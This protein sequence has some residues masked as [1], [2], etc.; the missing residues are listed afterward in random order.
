LRCLEKP[1]VGLCSTVL[2]VVSDT[3]ASSKSL[4]TLPRQCQRPSRAKHGQNDVPYPAALGRLYSSTPSLRETSRTCSRGWRSRNKDI[5]V[6]VIR[7]QRLLTPAVVL[8]EPVSETSTSSSISQRH[9]VNHSKLDKTKVRTRV[10]NRCLPLGG[11][12]KNRPIRLSRHA[13]RAPT[14][15][16][17]LAGE[18]RHDRLVTHE[19]QI[20][21]LENVSGGSGLAVSRLRGVLTARPQ[22]RYPSTQP[23]RHQKAGSG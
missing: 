7:D 6:L 8:P 15:G 3:S 17:P 4:T 1:T 9:S 11:S 10:A 14:E 19:T 22:I 2:K 12:N 5:H 18:P 16:K 20:P 13:G 23:L 21:S